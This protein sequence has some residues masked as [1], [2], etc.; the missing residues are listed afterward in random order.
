VHDGPGTSEADGHKRRRS[1]P[2]SCDIRPRLSRIFLTTLH[3]H[4]AVGFPDDHGEL[5]LRRGNVQPV[6]G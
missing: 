6:A 4:T 3:A 1:R 5:L 2:L